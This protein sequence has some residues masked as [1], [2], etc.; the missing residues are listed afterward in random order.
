MGRRYVERVVGYVEDDDQQP[1]QQLSTELA[2]RFSSR[3]LA[4]ALEGSEDGCLREQNIIA[5]RNEESAELGFSEAVVQTT[6]AVKQA[7]WT[8]KATLAYVAVQQRS[9]EL[10]EQLA[11]ENRARV[12]SGSRRRSTLFRRRPKWRSGGESIRATTAAGDAEDHLRA[13]SWIQPIHRSGACGSNRQ[14]RPSPRAC[15]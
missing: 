3:V 6:A 4:A 13:R 1:I 12:T 7:Y 10:A 5:N 2:V 14:T 8:L 9:L 15:R 11:R